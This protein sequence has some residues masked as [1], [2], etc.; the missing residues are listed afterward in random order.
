M[1]LKP[2]SAAGDRAAEAS[3]FGCHPIHKAPDPYGPSCRWWAHWRAVPCGSFGLSP[4]GSHGIRPDHQALA[5]EPLPRAW[6]QGEA[7]V[8]PFRAGLTGSLGVCRPFGVFEPHL[9]WPL[10]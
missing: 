4:V 6:L 3:T 8:S 1:S 5:D 2:D 9:V 10:T 7:P